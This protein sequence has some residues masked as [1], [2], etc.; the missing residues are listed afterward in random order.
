VLRWE[1]SS[2]NPM[3]SS[4][5][6]SRTMNADAAQVM[7][8]GI[9]IEKLRIVQGVTKEGGWWSF[10]TVLASG[11]GV[12]CRRGQQRSETITSHQRLFSIPHVAQYH[13]PSS[14]PLIYT[15]SA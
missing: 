10:D 12:G 5:R 3:A 1:W 11:V 9:G 4:I 15:L 8:C 14:S 2:L 6:I 7:W 13:L